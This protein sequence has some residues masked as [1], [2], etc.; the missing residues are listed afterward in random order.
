MNVAFCEN[1]ENVYNILIIFSQNYGDRKHE[2]NTT[3]NF[4]DNYL[5]KLRNNL[6]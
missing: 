3:N 5:T 4:L 1:F 6:S 2:N